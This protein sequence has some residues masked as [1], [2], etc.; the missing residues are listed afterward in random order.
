MAYPVAE[1]N[2]ALAGPLVGSSHPTNSRLYLVRVTRIGVTLSTISCPP[3]AYDWKELADGSGNY[4][5]MNEMEV[6]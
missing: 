2:L 3:K 4:I 6:Q 1:G 5:G